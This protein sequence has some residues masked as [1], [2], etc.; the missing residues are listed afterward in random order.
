M[1]MIPVNNDLSQSQAPRL[2]TACEIQVLNTQNPD[3]F[4]LN[5]NFPKSLCSC[6]IFCIR[7]FEAIKLD[8]NSYHYTYNY[9]IIHIINQGIPSEDTTDQLH[10]Q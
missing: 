3:A 5:E 9:L 6:L 2:R 7:V 8:G 10:L 1:G 4:S